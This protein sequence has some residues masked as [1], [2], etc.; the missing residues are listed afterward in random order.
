MTTTAHEP[1]ARDLEVDDESTAR[2]AYAFLLTLFGVFG[3][4]ALVVGLVAGSGKSDGRT[5]ATAAEPTAVTL[6][7]F[8]IWWDCDPP[9]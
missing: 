6:S 9:Y 4:I 1:V 7:E 8:A 3:V 5:T 2:Q